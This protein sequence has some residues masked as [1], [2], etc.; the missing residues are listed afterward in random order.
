[1]RQ[2][3]VGQ[4]LA[5]LEQ[6][7]AEAGAQ[8]EDELESRSGDDPGPVHLGI[9]EDERGYAEPRR[10]RRASVETGPLIDELGDRA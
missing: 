8:G 4:Q 2:L 5:A 7:D 3:Q 6:R 9:V 10:D 1:M